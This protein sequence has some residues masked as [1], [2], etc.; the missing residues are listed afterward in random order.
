MSH[1]RPTHAT[2]IQQVERRGTVY[3]RVPVGERVRRMAHLG[4][5]PSAPTLD[6]KTGAVSGELYGTFQGY[7]T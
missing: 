7:Q 4:R 5:P 1:N 6:P 3:R 2:L